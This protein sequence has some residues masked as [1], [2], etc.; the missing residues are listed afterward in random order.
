MGDHLSAYLGEGRQFDISIDSIIRNLDP[1]INI[2]GLDELLEYYFLLS[3]EELSEDIK[4]RNNVSLTEEDT[5]WITD[6]NGTPVGVQDF[7]GLLPNR[8]R[9]LDPALKQNLLIQEG[10]VNG[11]VDWQQTLKARSSRGDFQGQTYACRVQER[12]VNTTKN[13]VLV[14]LIQVFQAIL[15]RFDEAIAGDKQTHNWFESWLQTGT[16]RET[17]ATAINNVY[18]GELEDDEI[19][20]SDRALREVRSDRDPLYREAATLLR[21]YRQIS[22]QEISDEQVKDLFKANLFAPSEEDTPVLFELYWIFQILEHFE[23]PR[24]T[25]ITAE[26]DDL[27]AAWESDSFRY[28]LFN[29]WG[30]HY[31]WD[32]NRQYKEYLRIQWEWPET[33]P[34]E[35]GQE[36]HQFLQRRKA[37]NERHHEISKSVFDQDE[38]S[39]RGRQRPDI[40]LLK[41]DIT[42][43]IPVL[44]KTFIG[45][46]KYSTYTCYLQKG[47]RELLQYGAHAL[48]GDN[49]RID[50]D[51]NTDYLGR[52]PDPLEAPELE[53]G[54]FAGHSNRVNYPVPTGIQ[55]YGYGDSV[56]HPF[57]E[58]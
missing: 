2:E 10:T 1:H 37:I 47:L 48:Q 32:D 13:R 41:L 8:L 28:L 44:E 35:I 45:E 39:G 54:L 36:A 21:N 49:L 18:L 46:I 26:Q 3:G 22:H 27:I 15:K 53:L 6:V 40:V 31:R 7:V 25:Q 58:H 19:N 24:Y 51:N 11:H 50:R 55:V 14:E 43:A 23:D 12:T 17:L 52:T 38:A 56:A 5:A 29:D 30:G 9:S 42:E 57:A 20:V 4:S 33:D 16:L 34:E